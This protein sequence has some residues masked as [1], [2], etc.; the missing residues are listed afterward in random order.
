MLERVH[1]DKRDSWDTYEMDCGHSPF[2][3]HVEELT[4]ILVKS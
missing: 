1:S 4:E 2:L 3:S